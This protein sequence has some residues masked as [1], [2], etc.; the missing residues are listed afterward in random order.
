M[1]LHPGMMYDVEVEERPGGIVMT[2]PVVCP[3][4]SWESFWS[5]WHLVSRDTERAA[6]NLPRRP[7]LYTLDQVG[8]ILNLT[9]ARLRQGKYLFFAG[10]TPG[11]QTKDE[12]LTRNIAAADEP[13]EW[14][15]EERELIRWLKRK[16]FRVID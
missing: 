8:T 7:F 4:A 3:Y 2:Q 12:M 13:P 11:V 9:E 6:L 16:G 14:R 15:I 10:R 1:G 5:N